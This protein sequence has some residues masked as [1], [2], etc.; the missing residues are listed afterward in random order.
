MKLIILISILFTSLFSRECYMEKDSKVCFTRYYMVHKLKNPVKYQKHYKS[1]NGYIYTF[2]DKLKV[3]LRYTG[4]ILY[5]VDNFEVKYYDKIN[6]NT[7]ILQAN[8]PNELFSII[9]NLN[10][11]DSVIV[12]SPVLKRVFEKGY[13]KPVLN[14]A[15][16][17]TTNKDDIDL[18]KENK[19]V[20]KGEN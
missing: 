16:S 1:Q 20:P 10:K 5:I 8:N 13:Q 12:S 9:T 4:A 14:K 15:K 2:K 6:Q 17:R 19:N 3:T 18:K 7:H 11:L